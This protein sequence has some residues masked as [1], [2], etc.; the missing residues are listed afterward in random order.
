MT[1]PA[2]RACVVSRGTPRARPLSKGSHVLRQKILT[3]IRRRRGV[4]AAELAALLGV[5][6]IDIRGDLIALSR[7]GEIRSV[8]NTRAAKWVKA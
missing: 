7:A 2:N 4:S 8:G 3:A 1:G 5:R 6:P